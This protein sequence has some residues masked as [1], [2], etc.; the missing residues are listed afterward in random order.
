MN[1]IAIIG[2]GLVGSTT[3]FTLA[4]SAT[5]KEIVLIDIDKDKAIGDALDISHGVPLIRPVEVYAGDYSDAKG[6]DIII[7][8]AGVGQKPGETRLDIVRRNTEVFKSIIPNLVNANNEAVYLI[9]SNPVD[10]L[11]YVTYKIS[12][13]PKNQVI[14]S[15]TVLDSSRLKYLLSRKLNIDPRNIHG[16][17]IGEHGDSELAAWSISNV[18]GIPL[19]KYCDLNNIDWNDDIK[20]EIAREVIESAYRILNKKGA[21]YYAVAI[22][23][24][25]IVE[26]IYRD[27]KS[28]FSVS[29]VLDGQYGLHNVSL[30]LPSILDGSGVSKILELPLDDNEIREFKE[31]A[32]IMESVLK[33]IGF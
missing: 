4:A 3:A 20:N 31:S 9:V 7:I 21:T 17:I 13:L 15:G 28:I 2:S 29:S 16:Y 1:K 23:V 8:S 30:S 32:Q 19:E 24:R 6:A 12:E 14:G 11:T 27:E 22:A 5:T 25:R 26:S 33:D 10:I 18:G